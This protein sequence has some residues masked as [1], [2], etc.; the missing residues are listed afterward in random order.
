MIQEKK[1]IL[2]ITISLLLVLCILPFGAAYD[3]TAVQH[4]EKN[5][6]SVLFIPAFM[7]CPIGSAI[8]NQRTNFNSFDKFFS[9]AL[10]P[11][12]R[13]I[14]LTR[15]YVSFLTEFSVRFAKYAWQTTIT[16]RAPPCFKP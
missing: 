14:K 9:D 8:N 7:E 16:I 12:Q 2:R 13:S 6:K 15:A 4:R 1:N 5:P 11:K 10:V 3:L